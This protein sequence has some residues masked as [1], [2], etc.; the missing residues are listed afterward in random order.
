MRY[1]MRKGTYKEAA[2][3]AKFVQE[4]DVLTLD[5]SAE[6]GDDVFVLQFQHQPSLF[7]DGVA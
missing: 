6:E 7:H 3:R 2:F 1:L 4:H 5:A